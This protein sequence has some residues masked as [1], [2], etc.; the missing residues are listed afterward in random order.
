MSVESPSNHRG[1]TSGTSVGEYG[2]RGRTDSSGSRRSEETIASGTSIDPLWS[3]VPV[4]GSHG[5]SHFR[6]EHGL[7]RGGGLE[8]REQY[9]FRHLHDSPTHQVKLPSISTGTTPTPTTTT[10]LGS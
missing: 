6:H 3:R 1:E 2:F 10:L 5:L 7:W 4:Q 9:T 8:E